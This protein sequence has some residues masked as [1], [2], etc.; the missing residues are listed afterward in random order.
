VSALERDRRSVFAPKEASR[1]ALE[2]ASGISTREPDS[3]VAQIV[4]DQRTVSA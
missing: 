3:V 4:Y 1:S 2:E